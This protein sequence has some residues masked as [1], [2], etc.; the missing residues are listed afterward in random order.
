MATVLGVLE[1]VEASIEGAVIEGIEAGKDGGL[2]ILLADGRML[3]I[4]D[5]E[6]VALI[7]LRTH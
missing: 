4:P 3:I 2:Q 7:R 1:E 5:A 6:I